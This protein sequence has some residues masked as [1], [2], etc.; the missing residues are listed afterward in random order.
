MSVAVHCDGQTVLK[1]FAIPSDDVGASSV[2][3]M[4]QVGVDQAQNL[5]LLLRRL[6]PQPHSSWTR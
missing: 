3:K 1:A 4:V 5:F 6:C 2:K